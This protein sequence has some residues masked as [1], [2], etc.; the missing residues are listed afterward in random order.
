MKTKMRLVPTMALSAVL[1]SCALALAACGDGARAGPPERVLAHCIRAPHL[2]AGISLGQLAT[3]LQESGSDISWKAD[4]DNLI[5]QTSR[6]DPLT[7]DRSG[8][9]FEIL[10]SGSETSGA[11]FEGC[12]SGT[13]EITRILTPGG[14]ASGVSVDM[15]IAR[16]ADEIGAR[17]QVSKSGAASP[18]PPAVA[19][20]EFDAAEGPRPGPAISPSFD[21]RRASSQ[22][23]TL[24]CSSEA[25]ARLD[26][27]MV[28]LYGQ[29][30]NVNSDAVT[31]QSSWLHQR[32]SCT[33]HSCIQSQYE[34][35]IA[36]FQDRLREAQYGPS[37]IG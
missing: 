35:R 26:N 34:E 19:A 3:F 10:L 22:V 33:T 23:E 11:R 32:N 30:R 24:I 9:K 27:D 14:I 8:L 5:L 28:D 36:Y 37:R 20:A 7:N 12:D 21:C 16:M 4:G 2:D 25:L 31:D 18:A 17:E 1:A 29:V 15:I 13:A 6:V